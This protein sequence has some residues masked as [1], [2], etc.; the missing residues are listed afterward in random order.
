[1]IMEKWLKST[2]IDNAEEKFE[3]VDDDTFNE[4]S[5]GNL[6]YIILDKTNR[7]H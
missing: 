6:E 3:H 2:S 7:L 5:H 4:Q 1:M